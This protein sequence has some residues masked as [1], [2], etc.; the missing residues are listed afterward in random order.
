MVRLMVQRWHPSRCEVSIPL[1][2]MRGISSTD[3]H[4]GLQGGSG[5]RL[6]RSPGKRNG[7]E[8][9]LPRGRCCVWPLSLPPPH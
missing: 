8:A 9:E 4:G 6:D 1:R 3:Q 5:A 7:L 2:A